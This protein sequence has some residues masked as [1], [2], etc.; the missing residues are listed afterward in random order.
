MKSLFLCLKE[1]INGC[2]HILGAA[3][4]LIGTIVLVYQAAVKATVWHIVSFAIYGFSL[5]S[6]YTMSSL[7]HSLKVSE[8]TNTLLQQ[9]DHA[10]IYLLIA[11]TY[12]P[13]CLVLLRNGWGWTILGINWLLAI[14][15]I[16]LKIVFP[17]PHQWVVVVLFIFFI[18][19]GWLIVVAW[20][21]LVV[22]LPSE[23]IYWLI[24]GGLFYTLG[25]IVLNLKKLKILPGFGAHELWHFFVIAGSF[26]HY[27]LMLRYVMVV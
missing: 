25:T 13:V 10:M 14:T 15:G 19:M 17:R 18:I 8:K 26:C 7:Y 9:L 3:L 21:P 24:A 22:V 4:A 11:G 23:G 6:L 2:T 27:W 16:V 5:I 20:K 12:T 1:P